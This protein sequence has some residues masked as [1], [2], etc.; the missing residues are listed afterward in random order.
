MKGLSRLRFD[1]LAGYTRAPQAPLLGEEVEWYAEGDERIL[2]VL[3]RDVYDNDWS[4]AILARDRKGRFRA[5]EV[6]GFE[7]GSDAV[8][9]RLGEAMLKWVAKPDADYEQGDEVGHGVDFLQPVVAAERL[10]PG[11]VAMGRNGF[12]P[13]K[14]IIAAMMA[15]YE[16]PDGN[17]IEQFQTTGFDARLWE[18]YLFAT[19][20][21]LG[22]HLDRAYAAPDFFCQGVLGD[23][24]VEA[25]TV[26]ATMVNNISTEVGPP[27]AGLAR[28]RYFANYLPIKFGSALY[29]K[30]T[31]QY[32]KLP[33]IGGRPIVFAV[34]D[35]HWPGSMSWSEPSLVPYLYGRRYKPLHDQEGRLA[36][37]SRLVK[38]HRWGAKVIPSGFFSQ[39]EAEHISAVATNPQ[40][41]ISKFNRMGFLA[42]F[43]ARS[44][45]MLRSGTHY[46]HAA[47]AVRAEH[48]VHAVDAPDY[49]ET[50][51]E[52]MNVYHNPRA[53]VPL[54]WEMLPGAAHH[55]LESNG[56]MSSLIPAFHPFGTQTVIMA[57][58]DGV[59]PELIA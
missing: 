37:S 43:G 29:S 26:N 1:A 27:S 55:F 23:L 48:F 3:F 18:L 49:A 36:I 40:G 24:F 15:Y 5:V 21:E 4:A 39:P 31:R 50:W 12:S 10:N 45:R 25:V 57:A 53:N 30:L 32:W 51:V 6:V 56:Q 52:G 35:F 33:H 59:E 14:E 2:A 17:F 38:E 46:V 22:Y 54:P 13:A 42:E 8:R 7:E 28:W 20:T 34:Q 44:V 58:V 9:A 16:D 47:D 11:F 19:L 41:T